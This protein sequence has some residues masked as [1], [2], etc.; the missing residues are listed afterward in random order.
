ME[1]YGDYKMISI[2][3]L[4]FQNTKLKILKTDV[5]C[6]ILNHLK[7]VQIIGLK[8]YINLNLIQ[9]VIFYVNYLIELNNFI[10][11]RKIFED[12]GTFSNI[13]NLNYIYYS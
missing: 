5:K 11:N 9:K 12:I 7:C 4:Q 10:K 13:G 1:S 6:I 8:T 3:V 2:A